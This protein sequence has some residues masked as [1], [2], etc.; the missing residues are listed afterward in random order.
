MNNAKHASFI[1]G[2]RFKYWLVELKEQ[3]GTHYV[4]HDETEAG[5]RYITRLREE[6]D[7]CGNNRAILICDYNNKSNLWYIEFDKDWVNLEHG[8]IYG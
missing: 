8:E 5:D 1:D 2:I 4:Y 7:Q 6:Y 3:L